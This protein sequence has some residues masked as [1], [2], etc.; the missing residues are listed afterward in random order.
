MRL[1]RLSGEHRVGR[2]GDHRQVDGDAIALPDAEFLQRVGHPADFGVQLAIGDLLRFRRIVAF[3]DYGDLL[4]APGEVAIDAI[5]RH[6]QDAVM[7]PAD[8]NIAGVVDIAHRARAVGLD[9]VDTLAVLAPEL[10]RIGDR[11]VVHRLVLRLVDIGA[12]G[13]VRADGD[14]FV[15]HEIPPE[16]LVAWI[17]AVLARRRRAGQFCSSRSRPVQ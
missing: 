4:T 3:P 14:Q 15:A 5:R 12:L 9:P 10:D 16:C 7:E 17:A 13:P 8:A 1:A 11:G 6:V 2:L